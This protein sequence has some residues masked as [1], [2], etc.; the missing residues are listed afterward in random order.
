[1]SPQFTH[2]PILCPSLHG[3]W[4]LH[5]ARRQVTIMTR[6]PV[7]HYILVITTVAQRIICVANL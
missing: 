6:I 2:L 3:D 7:A 4:R 5:L 1:M